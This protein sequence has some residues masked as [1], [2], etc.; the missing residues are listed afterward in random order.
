MVSAGPEVRAP[1]TRVPVFRPGGRDGLFAQPVF[2]G[3]RKGG[4]PLVSAIKRVRGASEWMGGFWEKLQGTEARSPREKVG[5]FREG[6]GYLMDFLYLTAVYRRGSPRY[7][8][9]A[10]V[11]KRV[12]AICVI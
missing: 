2:P 8:S 10:V 4:C 7:C 11:D 12:F 1:G 5:E 9:P 3:A 6:F